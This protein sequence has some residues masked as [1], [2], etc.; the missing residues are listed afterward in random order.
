MKTIL[1]ITAFLCSALLITSCTTTK[2]TNLKSYNSVT[3][4]IEGNFNG[5]QFNS[6]SSNPEKPPTMLIRGIGSINAGT[7]PL[8][9]VDGIPYDGPINMINPNDI[10]SIRV[11]KDPNETIIYGFR[12]ANGVVL[13]QTKG[14]ASKPY[15]EQGK[16]KKWMPPTVS[17]RH[18]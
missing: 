12:G 8:Y 13:I 6:A 9:V 14:S 10:E 17:R 16:K 7:D 1:H 11:L 4:A 2:D 18:P 5:V 3:Q 15:G